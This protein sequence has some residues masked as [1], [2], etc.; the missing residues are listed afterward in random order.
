MD[1]LGLDM[2]TAIKAYLKQISAHKRIPFPLI[3]ANGLTP[4][5]EK[6]IARSAKE[7][8]QGRN[9]SRTYNST[10]EMLNDLNK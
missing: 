3:T 5:E 4:K 8:K 1:E 9:V 7:A 2:S 6:Q 10:D